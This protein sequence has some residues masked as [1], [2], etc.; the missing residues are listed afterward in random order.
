MQQEAPQTVVL[1][2][3]QQKHQKRKHHQT[4]PLSHTHTQK[5]KKER[6]E[7]TI[8]VSI[9]NSITRF[10]I[11]RKWASTNALK[12]LQPNKLLICCTRA[13][14]F[15]FMKSHVMFFRRETIVASFLHMIALICKVFI[16]IQFGF[17]KKV[18]YNK[19]KKI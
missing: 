5:K 18:D 8:T 1:N 2:N 9:R 6:K 17:F 11:R 3:Y 16:D 13:N 4:L 19:V 7:I 12:Y 14:C 10:L 15:H